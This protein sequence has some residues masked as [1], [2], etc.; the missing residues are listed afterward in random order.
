METVTVGILQDVGNQV[1]LVIF[2]VHL[3][4]Q[5]IEHVL[6]FFQHTMLRAIKTLHVKLILVPCQPFSNFYPR[7][8][9]LFP[10]FIGVIKETKVQP[11]PASLV[12]T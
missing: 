9:Q 2:P 10:A 12:L 8:V 11:C 7:V 6:R 3:Q 5:F 1:I 4:R